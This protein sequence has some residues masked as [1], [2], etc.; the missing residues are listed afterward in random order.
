MNQKI[1]SDL[2]VHMKYARY[3]PQ[4]QRRELWPEICERYA[5]MMVERYPHMEEEIAQYLLVQLHP[6]VG[7]D[8]S[9]FLNKILFS[10]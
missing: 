4:Y 5:R 2:I 3:L 10:R 9:A 8:Y 1:L 7:L 6:C